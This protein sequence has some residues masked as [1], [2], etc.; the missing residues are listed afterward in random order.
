MA[1]AYIG[2]GANLG[3]R[4]QTLGEALRRLRALGNVIAVS[5]LYET[6]P[7]GYEAQPPFLNAAAAVETSLTPI[8]LMT[9][10]L[11]IERE[12]GRT[13][14]FRNAPRTLDL[15]LLLYDDLVLDTPGLTLPHPR[16]HE[17]AFVLVPLAEIAPQVIHPRLGQSITAL[18]DALPNRSGVRAWSQP[19]E[20]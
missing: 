15:D 11:A 10:L 19:S 18:L 5:A 2:L 17:R 3:D 12:L 4:E 14:T 20:K 16:F 7:V 1:T 8:D 13:R 9:G 6:A